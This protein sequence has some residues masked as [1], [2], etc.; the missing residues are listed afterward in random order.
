MINSK[1]FPFIVI[2]LYLAVFNPLLAGE[3]KSGESITVSAPIA[4]DLYATAGTVQVLSPIQG[5]ANLIGGS[6]SVSSDIQQ[7]LQ[8]AGGT[9]NVSGKVNDDARIAGGTIVASGDILG[10]G[11]FTGGTITIHPTK[12]GGDVVAAGGTVELSSHVGGKAII[13]GGTVS[14]V[15][16]I[17]GDM[18]IRAETVR[19]NGKIGGNTKVSAVNLEIGPDAKFAGT[20]TYWSDNEPDFHG[21]P[22]KRDERLRIEDSEF[23]SESLMPGFAAAGIIGFFISLLSGAMSILALLLF[24]RSFVNQAGDALG[25]RLTN[26]AGRGALFLLI[27]PMAV[28]LLLITIAGIP[29]GLLWMAVFGFG[30]IFAK[31]ITA[32]ALAAHVLKR[33]GRTNISSLVLYGS[34]LG[35]FVVMK[36]IGLIPIVGILFGLFWFLIAAGLV[37]D[38]VAIMRAKT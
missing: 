14:I 28:L 18:T 15:G 34:A 4:G 16:T 6:I 23:H 5:D 30:I 31:A 21:Q 20:I 36:L 29:L 19:I 10:D 1:N 32:G 38:Q 22:A 9:V 3:F 37:I 24:F 35:I 17:D 13:A 25:S 27:S 12:I 7:D 33:M 8:A 2:I 11:L 26:I